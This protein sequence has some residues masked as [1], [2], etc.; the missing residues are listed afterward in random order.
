[1]TIP[2]LTPAAPLT[3]DRF[4]LDADGGDLSGPSGCVPLSPKALAVLHYLAR[5]PARLI[6]KSELIEAHWADV[7]VADSVIRL[8]IRE[9]RHAVEDDAKVPRFIE[10][11]HRLGY[12]FT[13]RVSVVPARPGAAQV[14]ASAETET[15][16][17]WLPSPDTRC[18]AR[19]RVAHEVLT[20]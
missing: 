2:T 10:T 6:S 5:R 8:C 13:A 19:S 3:F 11:V 7:F 12:R 20:A 9:I 14:A 16:R 15:I 18:D 4:R 17:P 1:M